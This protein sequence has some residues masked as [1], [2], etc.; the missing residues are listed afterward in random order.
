MKTRNFLIM[1]LI[2]VGICILGLQLFDQQETSDLPKTER[3]DW[4][5]KAEEIALE[6]E[7]V[8]ELVDEKPFSTPT[9]IVYNETYV[10]LFFRIGGKYEEGR[11]T[12][13]KIYKIAIELEDLDN[14][15]VKFVKEETN[16]T[17]LEWIGAINVTAQSH[18]FP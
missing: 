8:Q 10:E 6:D 17:V 5:H 16:Q 18:A 11:L 9:G 3:I 7:K 1:V 14:G 12:G 2:V 15:T 13:G 4:M